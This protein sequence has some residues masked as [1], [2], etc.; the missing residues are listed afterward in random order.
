[1]WIDNHA[2]QRQNGQNLRVFSCFL[3]WSNPVR[4]IFFLFFFFLKAR[5]NGRQEQ[6]LQGLIGILEPFGDFQMAGIPARGRHRQQLTLD[7]DI[8]RYDLGQDDIQKAVLVIC[9]GL[10]HIHAQG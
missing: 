4:Q 9:I 2:A 3:F 1:M 7:S 5:K 6:I 8:R 10:A